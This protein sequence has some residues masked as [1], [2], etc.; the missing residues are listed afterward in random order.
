MLQYCIRHIN[1]TI[2][3]NVHLTRVHFSGHC[4]MIQS[5]FYKSQLLSTCNHF[6][7]VSIDCNHCATPLISWKKVFLSVNLCDKIKFKNPEFHFIL[8]YYIRTNLGIKVHFFNHAHYFVQT[9]FRNHFYWFLFWLN[10]SVS[11]NNWK[12][13]WSFARVFFD[14]GIRECMGT[15]DVG[16]RRQRQDCRVVSQGELECI[17]T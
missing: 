5:W 7:N 4:L 14:S 9:N 11:L 6:F 3:Q 15:V 10:V 17:F 1:G 13:Y 2:N 16:T 12:I 8:S